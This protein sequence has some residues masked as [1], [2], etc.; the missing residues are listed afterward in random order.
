MPVIPFLFPDEPCGGDKS[1][2][3]TMKNDM[4]FIAAPSISGSTQ[5]RRPSELAI[6]MI[7]SVVGGIGGTLIVSGQT[8][9]YLIANSP[10]VFDYAESKGVKIERM[11]C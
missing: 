2:P 10:E 5:E 3:K 7:D 8:Y 11:P 1:K 9:E 6:E 4:I